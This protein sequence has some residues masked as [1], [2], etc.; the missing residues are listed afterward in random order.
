MLQVGQHKLY[1]FEADLP[2]REV[3]DWFSYKSSGNTISFTVP[4]NS[5]ENL[6]GFGLWI[7]YKRKYTDDCALLLKAV[8][9]NKTKNRRHTCG[10]I[11]PMDAGVGEVLSAVRCMD[12]N[13][14]KSG[15]K[16]KISFLSTPEDALM[17]YDGVCGLVKVK[18]CGAHLIQN[19]FVGISDFPPIFHD[20]VRQ[21]RINVKT[22]E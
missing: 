2:N 7:V 12:F 11:L 6:F 1:S 14:M 20:N 16:V 15:D 21:K 17:H 4:P 3:A 13:D 5:G 19:N 10:L 8:I 22:I 18:M 9:T